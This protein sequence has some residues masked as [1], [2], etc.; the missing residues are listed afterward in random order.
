[1]ELTQ[2]LEF[3]K[4]QAEAG[5][6]FH[7][8]AASLLRQYPVSIREFV[9]SPDY[10]D[11]STIY[12]RN[13][14][15]LEE[16]NNPGG[17]RIGTQYT[18]AILAGGI[19]VGKTTLALHS[20]AYQIYQLCCLKSP[21][22]L[23]D[24][25]STS[26]IVLVIQSPTE[27]LA[28]AVGFGRLSEMIR[29]ARCFK[30]RNA[31]DKNYT[32]E[33]RF[34]NGVV[35]RPL[36]GATTAALG[37]NVLGGMLDE[38]A[39]A[40]FVQQSVRA[41]G[42]DVFDQAETQYNTISKRRKSRFLKG[43]RLPGLLCLV[44]SPQHPDDL[45]ERK[46]REASEDSSIF[47]YQ[48][49]L[50]DVKPDNYSQDRFNVFVGDP[51][52][53]PRILHDHEEVTEPTLTE[54]VP[55]DFL[56]DFQRDIDSAIRDLCGRSSQAVS[57]F[58]RNKSAV[59]ACFNPEHRSVFK[60]QGVDFAADTLDLT[61]DKDGRAINFTDAHLSR[62]CH[63]DLALSRDSAGVACG[64]IQSFHD[65][66]DELRPVIMVDFVL[67]IR[68]PA[69]GEI[70]LEKIRALLLDLRKRGLPITWV[71]F[72]GYQS[73]DSR[74]LLSAQGLQTGL[75]SMDRTTEPY[76]CLRQALYDQRVLIPPH[77]KLQKELLALQ[78]DV[79]KQKVDHDSRNSKDLS[80]CLAGVVHGLTLSR[81][82]RAEHSVY[83]GT[84]GTRV[85]AIGPTLEARVS[86]H[87][88]AVDALAESIAGDTMGL[89]HSRNA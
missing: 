78:F 36:S 50:W 79:R 61:T 65:F 67:E 57:P 70:S 32:S 17:L 3:A 7:V 86:T 9:E 55:L 71:S 4:A 34:R 84:V 72:D 46:L 27:K 24:L 87:S 81:M 47:T 53:P 89:R 48:A 14:Q 2:Y 43:G 49:R 68:P 18:E 21:Q 31:P 26:E 73:A 40:A 13:M 74:Q 19:G 44:S 51:N 58:L 37:Q 85:T 56:K 5:D 38:I 64:F 80:D 25:P 8:K 59:V 20:L 66:E 62:W 10:L 35:L 63:V 30:G 60:Q 83:G 41:R 23:F 12:P 42:L 52:R 1:M 39:F 54:A 11:D 88:A 69:V 29:G 75:R 6:P 76:E 45:L 22:A 82:A 15:A 33:L 16:L 28:K 77:S